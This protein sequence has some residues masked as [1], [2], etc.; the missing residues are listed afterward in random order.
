[1]Q[2]PLDRSA[3]TAIPVA[4]GSGR[5]RHRLALAAAILLAGL[6]AAGYLLSILESAESPWQADYLSLYVGSHHL[7]QGENPYLQTA[8]LEAADLSAAQDGLVTRPQAL[9]LPP[10][11]L[12]L[13]APFAELPLAEGFY[14]FTA[15]SF[16]CLMISLVWLE[17]SLGQLYPAAGFGPGARRL[18]FGLGISLLF[19]PTWLCLAL[20]QP[21]LLLLAPL[22]LLRLALLQGRERTAGLLLGLL[23]TQIPGLAL[24]LVFLLGTGARRLG[25]WAVLAALAIGVLPAWLFNGGIYEN[26]INALLAASWY[27]AGWNSSLLGMTTPLF[28]FSANAPLL[29]APVLALGLP[30]AGLVLASAVL[31]RMGTDLAARAQQG[32]TPWLR[33]K[34]LDLGLAASLP[35]ALLIQP[36]SWLH[37]FVLLLP[38]LLT[39]L[40]AALRRE[41]FWRW[42]ERL[43]IAWLLAAAPYPL[44]SAEANASPLLW[45]GFPTFDSYALMVLG[46]TLF[47]LYRK[48][49]KSGR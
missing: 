17:R 45:V 31:W 4:P 37:G 11:T 23:M 24:L 16:L 21:Y 30:A 33:G 42:R 19:F 49:L 18:F 12:L 28:G 15:A 36:V 48:T 22:A 1:M 47:A 14:L 26:Y 38:A 43:L 7:V 29:E 41:D 5:A 46:I 27:G 44:V 32:A 6:L 35:A 3:E 25:L 39:G 34:L 40:E 2:T 13:V 20:G 10:V 8:W 9:L